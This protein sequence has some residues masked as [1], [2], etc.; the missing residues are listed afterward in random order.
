MFTKP[1]C[2]PHA[3]KHEQASS[4]YDEAKFRAYI[5][6]DAFVDI[7]RF[8][9]SLVEDVFL[10]LETFLMNC[11]PDTTVTGFA[12]STFALCRR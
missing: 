9:Q 3:T 7:K 2:C 1:K 6:H 4:S 5:L 10:I 11:F 12:A 8:L